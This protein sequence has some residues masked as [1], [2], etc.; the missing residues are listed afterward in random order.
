MN[1]AL[2]EPG[3]GAEAREMLAVVHRF[4]EEEMRPVGTELDR[5]ADPSEVIAEGSA[6]WKVFDRYRQLGLHEQGTGGYAGAEEALL[7][8]RIEEELGWGDAGLALSFAVSNFHRFFVPLTGNDELIEKFAGPDSTGIGCWAITEPDHGSDTLA[9]TEDHF[10]DASI[11]ADCIARRDG[12]D[13]VINGTKAAWVSNG[14]IADVA[15]LFCTIDGDEGFAGGGV[16]IVPLDL[17]GVSR[18]R[19][20]DKL[21]QRALPQGEIH[22]DDVRVPGSH[23]VV[24][25]D[26]YGPT[27][28]MVLAFAN[29][30]MGCTF[31]GV[32]RA[33]YDMAL[34]YA[35]ERV[36]GGVP[37]ISH[38][39]VRSRLF[40]MFA[41]VEAA[42]SLSRRVA[43]L[44]AGGPPPVQ[45]SIASKTFC[46][47]TAFEVASEALQIFGGNGLSR[48]YPIEKVLRD[49]RASMIED[50][51]NEVLSIVAGAKL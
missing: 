3:L 29:A 40:K 46:T 20:L 9:F 4:A 48:E 11:R 45:Y 19:P 18:G 39:S 23:M 34:A 49:A 21:G 43:L 6:F 28:E 44:G 37:I 47:T 26:F 31:S 5:L 35:R 24:G 25:K 2:A 10:A 50:G 32:A 13:W 17:P 41:R 14:T 15:S 12:D 38:Q 16:C 8:A 30:Y 36:Q 51:C 27:V 33:A 1:A 22:F 7:R 42:Q